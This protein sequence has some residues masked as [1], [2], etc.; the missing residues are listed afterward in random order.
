MESD[1]DGVQGAAAAGGVED[2]VESDHR[3][4][5]SVCLISECVTL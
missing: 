5:N 4:T 3:S 2:G 1:A